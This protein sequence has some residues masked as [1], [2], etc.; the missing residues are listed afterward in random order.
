MK[1][2]LRLIF[3]HLTHSTNHLPFWQ[4]WNTC[5]YQACRAFQVEHQ[6]IGP[7]ESPLSYKRRQCFD[8]KLV[9]QAVRDYLW[10]FSIDFLLRTHHS[11]IW[12]SPSF[13]RLNPLVSFFALI[14]WNHFR[15]KNC[16]IEFP[17][18]FLGFS[19]CILQCFVCFLAMS[20]CMIWFHFP[21]KPLYT[22]D[23]QEFAKIH[24][25]MTWEIVWCPVFVNHWYLTQNFC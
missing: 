14:Y 7:Y 23:F 20:H 16:W 8:S 17:H 11:F 21:L 1:F 6:H 5:F 13:I 2:I 3:W 4:C 19:W 12:L 22:M 9:I 18:S 10:S 24:T 25:W 15:M